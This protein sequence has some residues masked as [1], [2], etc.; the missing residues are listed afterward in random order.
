MACTEG[1]RLRLAYDAALRAWN[2]NHLR[3]FYGTHSSFASSQVRR[4]LLSARYEAAD[5]LYDHSVNCPSCEMSK[6][7]L[8]EDE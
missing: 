6:V 8:A 7:G 3:L 1:T 2:V 4:E 5:V